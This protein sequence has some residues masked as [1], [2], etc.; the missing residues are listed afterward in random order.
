MKTLT[1]SLLLAVA[2][3]TSSPTAPPVAAPQ[4]PSHACE[5]GLAVIANR[6][7]FIYTSPDTTASTV[8]QLRS[9]VRVCVASEVSGFGFRYVQLPDGRDGYIE[10]S[11]LTHL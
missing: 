7:A 6:G 4:V 2:C 1:L 3:A 11:H 10:D 5:K 8:E 9:D